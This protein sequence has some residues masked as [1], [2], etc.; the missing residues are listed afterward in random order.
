MEAVALATLITVSGLAIEKLMMRCNFYSGVRKLHC[1]GSWCSFDVDRVTPPISATVSG[2]ITPTVSE[3][4]HQLPL[5]R[6]SSS[7]GA[8]DSQLSRRLSLNDL[9]LLARQREGHYEAEPVP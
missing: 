8:S 6:R 5:P 9:V 7:E 1:G 2:A 3:P 4:P